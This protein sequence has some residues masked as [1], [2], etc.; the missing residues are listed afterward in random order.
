MTDP[1]AAAPTSPASVERSG[2]PIWLYGCLVG[3]VTVAIGVGIM[4]GLVWISGGND[5]ATCEG[6]IELGFAPDIAEQAA[7]EPD[8]QAINTRCRW[9]YA[10]NPAGQL[11]A[12]RTMITGRDCDVLWDYNADVWRCDTEIIDESELEEWPSKIEDRD[13][14]RTMFV[15]DF[16]SD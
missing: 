2:M 13:D 16:G 10:V 4:G 8:P 5:D 3:V 14:R 9:W 6:E 1:E 12:Y 11:V 7:A 15:V